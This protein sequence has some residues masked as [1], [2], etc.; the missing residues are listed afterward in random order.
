MKRPCPISIRGFDFFVA[1][2]WILLGI[3]NYRPAVAQDRLQP[4]AQANRARVMRNVLVAPMAFEGQAIDG[5]I[6]R[7]LESLLKVELSFV[8][9]VADLN[10]DERR[11]L[12]I[13]S[14]E[15]LDKFVVD[16]GKNMDPN[17][18]LMLQQGVRGFAV[19]GRQ[20]GD[21]PRQSIQHE[22]A[23]I[24]DDTLPE[25]KA[26]AYRS[27][28]AKR[29]EFYRDV[30]IA[31]LIECVDERLMLSTE[32]RQKI[33]NALAE[34]WDDGLIPQVEVFVTSAN[35]LPSSVEMWI[36]PELS[37]PQRRVLDRM[38]KLPQRAF[39]GHVELGGDGG[40]IDD[41]DLN[42]ESPAAADRPQE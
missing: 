6:R 42:L 28:C 39:F 21:S 12:V 10:D 15:W 19:R 18:R 33:A 14:V 16:F 1:A 27:E 20:E 36:R 26:A 7:Q 35:A 3:A 22:V 23:K 41:I 29:D 34:N 8:N 37:E 32:Q 24:V 25:Y 40:V 11:T 5:Q 17:Q 9:R 38:N 2:V 13:A 4:A 31:N 30:A